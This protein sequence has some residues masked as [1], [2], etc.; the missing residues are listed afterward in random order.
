MLLQMGP[1]W[2]VQDLTAGARVPLVDVESF[3]L[4]AR[5]PPDGA[6]MNRTMIVV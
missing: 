5:A 1:A 3:V 6:S 2:S 4:G